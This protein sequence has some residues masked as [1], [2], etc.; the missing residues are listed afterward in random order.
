MK[1]PAAAHKSA[2]MSDAESLV[3]RSVRQKIVDGTFASG[4]HLSTESLAALLGVSRTPVREALRR[5]QA[6][7]LVVLHANRG[8]FVA[9]WTRDDVDE[10]FDLRIVLEAHAS[11]HAAR[12][13]SDAAIEQLRELAR[14]MEA[15]VASKS[16]SRLDALS[17][18][19]E[20]F[21]RI[22]LAE[23]GQQ[24]LAQ[25][26]NSLVEMPMVRRTFGTYDSDELQRSM[27]HHRELIAAFAARDSV[28]ASAVM[29]S[30]LCAAH[31]V[32][33]RPQPDVA[34]KAVRTAA[35]PAKRRRTA[36]R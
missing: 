22:I 21:H 12:R 15:A 1:S 30:H 34:V 19:N 31:V 33:L 32:A 4:K 17:G 26:L 16:P 7:G 9:S 25:M 36:G 28:W 18:L 10:V 2:Q 8:A 20:E 29:R 23:C 27:F 14:R 24:R 5:M 13:I 3:Y 6:E 11:E 35:A